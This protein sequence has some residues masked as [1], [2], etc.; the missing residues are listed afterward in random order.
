VHVLAEPGRQYALYASGWEPVTLRLKVPEGRYRAE[1][2][3]PRSGSVLKYDEVEH[4]GGELALASPPP[5]AG[6]ALRLRRW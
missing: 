4:V 3:G 5:E 1:W 6:I 2:V